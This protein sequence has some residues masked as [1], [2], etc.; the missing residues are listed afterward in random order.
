MILML[1]GQILIILCAFFL[2]EIQAFIKDRAGTSTPRSAASRE[3][4]VG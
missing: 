3:D 2:F 4:L 1:F